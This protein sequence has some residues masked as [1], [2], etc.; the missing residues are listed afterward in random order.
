MNRI[1]KIILTIAVLSLSLVPLLWFHEDQLLIG[2]DNV[3]PLN[4]IDFL[5]D[6]I[7]S[8]STVQ[9]F[10]FDQSGQQGSLITHFIDALPQLFGFSPQVSQKITFVFWLFL[11]LLSPYILILSLEKAKLLRNA[12]AR[13]FFPVLYAFNFYILQAWW[14]AER[15]KFS[16]VVATPLILAIIL[17]MVFKSLSL[18]GIFRRS[19]F[20]SLILTLLNGGGWGGFPLYGGLLV[21]L[22]TFYAYALVIFLIQKRK[23]DFIFI[24]L[25]YVFFG[26]QFILFNAYTLLPFILTTFKEYGGQVAAVGGIAGLVG[27]AR[28][29]SENTSF[30]NL[31]RLQGIPDWYNSI[32][33]HPY[34]SFYLNKP[35]LIAAS[36][37]F[38]CLIFISLLI[39]RNRRMVLFF[40]L[41]LLISL[42][43][44]AGI[45]KPFG[46]IFEFL[47]QKIP[48]FII[49]R[50]PIFKFGYSFWLAGSFLI[51]LALGYIVESLAEKTKKI[52]FSYVLKTVLPIIFI[53]LILLYHFP[54]LKGDIFRISSEVGSRSEIPQYVYD[55]SKWWKENGKEDR[56]LF[57]P[58]LNS[59]WGFEQYKWGYLSLFPILGNFSNTGVVENTDLLTPTESDIIQELYSAINERNYE[60]MDRIANRLAISYF[61]VRK[62]FFYNIADQETDNPADIGKSIR[63]NPK[64]LGVSSF[65][66]WD[67]Y[68]YKETNPVIFSKNSAAIYNR[69]YGP[70]NPNSFFVEESTFLSYPTL[71]SDIIVSAECISCKAEREET[72]VFIPKPK[73]LLDSNLYNFVQLKN[74]FL[75]NK[76]ESYDQEIFHIVGNMLKLAGQMWELI[77]QDRRE[78]FV[79]LARTRYIELIDRLSQ[80]LE[81][82]E[83]KSSN[84]FSTIVIMEQYLDAQSNYLT[85][86][87]WQSSTKNVQINIEKVLYSINKLNDKLK[88]LYGEKDF[89]VK[90]QYKYTIINTDYYDLK[91]SRDSM[92]S[93]RDDTLIS[94][95]LDNQ[96]VKL[97]PKVEEKFLTLENIFLNKGTHFLQ[98]NLSSQNNLLG[99]TISQRISGSNCFSSY[100]KGFSSKKA[101]SLSFL[102]KNNFNQTFFY[103]IDNGNE[104]SPYH[105]GYFPL[106]G[107]EV[108]RNRVVISSSSLN[109]DQKSDTLRISFC[110]PA[111]TESFYKDSIKDLQLVFLP[112]PEIVLH[113]LVNTIS[114]SAPALT[115]KKINQAHYKVF[116]QNALNPFF[117]V[118]AQRYSSG[119]KSDV[120]DHLVGNR[121]E[122]AWLI[123]RKGSFWID[124]YY[125]PQAYFYYGL[126]ISG[127]SFLL[128]LLL[129]FLHKYVY[130]Q[131]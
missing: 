54:Y 66:E 106:Q 68:K 120:G 116:V 63:G 29:L 40:L 13:Y 70:L 45:H 117:L 46:F 55:F 91:I 56:I 95:Q 18:W 69:I 102:S 111:L 47:M 75:E 73:I 57:L 38:P 82:V 60:A 19:L 101:Y 76:I 61:L 112:E 64:I 44:S 6:R 27:W 65:G 30:I 32:L 74:K 114:G 11:L 94:L 8:W 31:F 90:K 5:K 108:K 20:C 89:N 21:V 2:Y 88:G 71:I 49:F 59:N 122:N 119:W 77:L 50:S 121:F 124:L 14:V 72:S 86:I 81:Q 93:L 78:Y 127:I 7:F 28:Y 3:Y 34:A 42:F 67:L 85:E 131:R 84:P 51:A 107:E 58:R 104:F 48:G 62:D 126:I 26:L 129:Y 37:I 33:Q 4:P 128:I 53:S 96:D 15:T 41:L 25:F 52:P 87:L 103:F 99:K 9:G 10:G 16:L 17:P 36:F 79:N 130:K 105:I 12:Y 98:L 110:S 118:F 24:T 1:E 92:G 39:K 109:L 35:I 113:G 123:D 80:K 115:L 43:F 100:L 125:A 83:R 97:I 23:K 22:L